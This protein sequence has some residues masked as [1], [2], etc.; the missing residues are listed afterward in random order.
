MLER[1]VPN[2]VDSSLCSF[3]R[4]L[5]A[6]VGALGTANAALAA[7]SCVYNPVAKTVTASITSNG[8][9]TLVGDDNGV[10]PVQLL[11]GQIPT[12]CG[13]ATTT[14]T[15]TINIS[16]SPGGIETLV[17]DERKGIFAPGATSEFSIS[18]S[19]STS[20]WMRER[21]DHRPRDP[22][23][24]ELAA[25]QNGVSLNGDGDVDVVITPG[26]FDLE[27]Y[28]LGG[29]DF[30]N[31]RGTFGAGLHFLGAI[32]ADAGAGDDFARGS[33]QDDFIYGRDGNDKLEGNGGNDLIDA[34]T[35]DNLVN[36]GADH[37]VIIAGPGHDDEFI[38]GAGDD[39][40]YVNDGE[41][42]GLMTGGAGADTIH[43]DSGLDTNF[44]GF[45]TQ[46]GSGGPQPPRLHR[47]RPHHHHL[48]LL[49]LRLRRRARACTTPARRR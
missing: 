16:G 14:N 29:N 30:F 36:A 20:T 17:L 25:G 1:G 32:V 46:V 47:L 19:S 5:G 33:T 21:H 39:V 44:T 31:G 15:D 2:D 6:L 10:A 37:D 28:L 18:E 27:V 49:L 35:G 3:A 22:G 9:A 48:L 11:F 38:A 4:A 43:F 40:L 23:R 34:G 8:Q 7:E 45:E 13:G 12:A 41:A 24:R 42:D 26:A